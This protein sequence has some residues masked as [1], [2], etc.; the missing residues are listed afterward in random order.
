[1]L[2]ANGARA[3]PVASASFPFEVIVSNAKYAHFGNLENEYWIHLFE[4]SQIFSGNGVESSRTSLVAYREGEDIS[5]GS[6]HGKEF[7]SRPVEVFNSLTAKH[8]SKF[9][10]KLFMRRNLRRIVLEMV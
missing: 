1:M 4:S 2:S 5:R 6:S 3:S 9:W 10:R 8:P 7:L